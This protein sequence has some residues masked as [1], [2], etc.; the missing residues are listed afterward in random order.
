M[1]LG[2]FDLKQALF[3]AEVRTRDG[4]HVTNV[5]VIDS[6]SPFSIRDAVDD[7]E[8]YKQGLEATIHNVNGSG[9]ISEDVFNFYHDGG[10]HIYGGENGADL[11]IFTPENELLINR[12]VPVEDTP[13][14]KYTPFD[15]AMYFIEQYGQID[16][17]HHKLWVMDQVA[18][19]HKGTDVEI[20]FR[21]WASGEEEYLIE[22]LEPT[23]EYHA[24]VKSRR[25]D[26]A[27]D[28]Y[29]YDIGIAP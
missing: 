11:M 2:K 17:V 15:W 18:R 20:T 26:D 25:F 7:D 16:G 10:A 13:Y 5:K 21:K 4:R 22:L 8:N 1:S 23:A 14:S 28:E 12:I 19:I 6:M 29:S 3:G 27:G 9:N 24:W